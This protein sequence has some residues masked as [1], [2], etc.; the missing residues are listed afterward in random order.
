[1]NIKT[2]YLALLGI[3]L[4]GL[5]AFL[6][7]F[8]RMGHND[9]VALS[10]FPRA[11]ENFDKA[12]SDY[13]KSSLASNSGGAAANH[14][15]EGNAD[16]A[17]A[18]L[19]TKASA[20]ISSLTRNDAELMTTMLEIADL[21]TKEFVTLKDYKTALADGSGDTGTLLNDFGDLTNQ[22]QTAYARFLKLADL[23]N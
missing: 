21:S 15:A 11:Y 6:F 23:K 3:A 2:K 5:A 7:F 14:D 18:T 19:N 17:L 4:I 13:S 8:Y 1:M 20:R 9:A 10:D 12:I 22:R 16:K